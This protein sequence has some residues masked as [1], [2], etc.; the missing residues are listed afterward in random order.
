MDSTVLNGLII[1]LCT[2][3]GGVVGSLFVNS[4]FK[5]IFSRNKYD[6]I[7]GIYDSIW[8]TKT[9]NEGFLKEKLVI[10]RQNGRR[11]YGYITFEKEPQ[12]RWEF[13]G[14]FTGQY[15]QLYYYPSRKKA[16][17]NL[18]LGNGCYFFERKIDG[19][20]KGFSVGVNE[21]SGILD[22]AVHELKRVSKKI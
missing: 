11:I 8:S 12:K 22:H 10:D 9:N 15:L 18:F 19:T 13:E 17:D 5:E 2:I 20:F 1:G 6:K 7:I 4:N 3:A 21:K 14:I 16:E